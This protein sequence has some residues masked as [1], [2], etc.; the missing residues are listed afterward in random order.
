MKR[1]LRELSQCDVSSDDL[2]SPQVTTMYRVSA[3]FEGKESRHVR[4]SLTEVNRIDLRVDVKDE[5]H[6]E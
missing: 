3:V 2:V 5:F 6:L 4:G 1:L